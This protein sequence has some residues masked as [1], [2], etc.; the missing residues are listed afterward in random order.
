MSCVPPSSQ[1]HTALDRY[2]VSISQLNTERVGL[3][4]PEISHLLHS[5]HE[6][7]VLFYPDW[8]RFLYYPVF[9]TNLRLYF[10]VFCLLDSVL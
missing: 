7:V 4:K 6:S 8:F 10:K 9:Y 3:V 5:L 2:P 1:T